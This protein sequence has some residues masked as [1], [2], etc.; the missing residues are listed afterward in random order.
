MWNLDASNTRKRLLK[1]AGV[2]FIEQ[3]RI[4][5]QPTPH[6]S[7]AICRWSPGECEPLPD[8]GKASYKAKKRY[9]DV[10]PRKMTAYRCSQAMLN[11]YG[12]HSRPTLKHNQATHD[13]SLSQIYV[14]YQRRWPLVARR[15]WRGEDIFVE[16]RGFGEKVEDA[17]L[18][19]RKTAQPIL[20]IECICK[21]PAR[22]LEAFFADCHR[23][24][25]AFACY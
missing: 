24:N 5:A 8:A 9:R 16:E 7:H 15:L 20:A 22:R 4:F 3:I 21:Y 17:L 19:H 12:L 6:V 23:R 1:L 10:T 11:A 13:L 25:L 14:E 18:I 2:G